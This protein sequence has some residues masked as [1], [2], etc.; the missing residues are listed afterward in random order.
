MRF[1]GFTDEWE[2]VK[3]EEMLD[4]NDGVRRGPF[5]SALKKEIFVEN[6]DY[7]V[8]EQQN[9]IYDNYKTRYNITKEKF[10]ELHKFTLKEN[11]FIMSGAGTIGR[12]SRVPKG[13]K[14]GVFNQALIRFRI[15]SELTNSEYFLQF[16]RAENMQRK[17]TGA[18]PGSAISNLVPMSEVKKWEVFVPIKGEQQ[19]IGELFQTL[20][21]VI[22]L[23]NTQVENL[24]QQK[25]ALLQRLFPQ[26]GETEPKVRLRGFTDDWEEVKLLDEI[27]VYQPKSLPQSKFLDEGYPVYGANGMIGYYDEYNHENRQIAMACRGNT[28]GVVNII[29]E[30]SYITGN[31]MIMD[32]YTNNK[33][34]F[35]FMG[36]LFNNFDFTPYISGSGQPQIT[37]SA[38]KGVYIHLPSLEE[39]QAIGE[40]FQSL[41]E[42]IRLAEDKVSQYEKLKQ[43]LLQRLFV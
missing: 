11:D 9:A 36:Q 12:I 38:L 19:K 24:K 27:E 33:L 23:S 42:Q 35:N 16:V 43:A 30:Q 2:Q 15:N 10:D 31:A 41:D 29:P 1:R 34:D 18:N 3:F 37:R 7:V 5:G 32:V 22:D 40:L 21:N 14:K 26:K 6:S 8:Y 39:Q 20:D 13:I 17:L 28:A 25:K 4:K